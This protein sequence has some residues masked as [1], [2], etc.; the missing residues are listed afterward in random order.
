MRRFQRTHFRWVVAS[1]VAGLC[2]ASISLRAF[3]ATVVFDVVPV[4]DLADGKIVVTPGEQVAYQLTA[5]VKSDDADTVDNNGL[6]YFN[7][8]IQ[9]D[10]GIVQAAM[11][12]FKT[13]IAESFT[14]FPSLGTPTDD[15]ILGISGRQD[16]D[17]ARDVVTE[18]AQT[19]QVLGGGVLNTPTTEETFTVKV[20]NDSIANVLE[21]DSTQNTMAVTVEIGDGFVISTGGSTDDDTTDDDTTD[22]DTTDD[23]TTDDDTTDDDTTDD[24]TTTTGGLVDFPTALAFVAGAAA[25]IVGAFFLGGNAAVMVALILVPLLGILAVFALQ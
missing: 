7:V 20:G 23:D 4:A 19:L 13:L 25:L 17:N 6:V 12:S 10:S 11:A 8:S 24:E 9:T 18:V 22:D 16:L 14:L 21:A 3:A 15:D 1:F 5:L 2:V